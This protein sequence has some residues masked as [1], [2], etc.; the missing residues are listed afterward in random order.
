[1]FGNKSKKIEDNKII[2]LGCGRLGAR[3]A[4]SFSIEGKIVTVIDRSKSSFRRLSSSFGGAMVVGSATDIGVL[5]DAR[6]DN[7]TTVVCVTDNENT[8]IMAAQ[9]VKH[10]C[11]AGRVICRLQDYDKACVYQDQS[12]ET[13][14]PAL[15]SISA[16]NNLLTIGQD[17]I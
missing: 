17:D 15:L 12:I 8:N 6:I 7:K 9:M 14:C 2:I 3:L 4:D 1:M 10:L 11:N 5:S 16:I 13:I